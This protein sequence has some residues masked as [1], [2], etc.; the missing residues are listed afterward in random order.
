M[1]DLTVNPGSDVQLEFCDLFDLG[2][3]GGDV[4]LTT[5]AEQADGSLALGPRILCSLDQIHAID[6]DTNNL[7]KDYTLYKDIDLEN[8]EYSQS[9]INGDYA[10]TFDGNYKTIR[11]LNINSSS[12]SVGFFKKIKNGGGVKN[13]R[14][15]NVSVK[16][17]N[18]QGRSNSPPFEPS[19][20]GAL[21][22]EVKEGSVINCSVTDSDS[23]SDVLYESSS[24]GVAAGGLVGYG[25][26]L[27]IE[28]SFS[29][30]LRIEIETSTNSATSRLSVGGLVGHQIACKGSCST[31][32]DSIVVGHIERSY[33]A[34]Q[35]IRLEATVPFSSMGG[36]VGSV[37]AG[38]EVLGL[39]GQP[40]IIKD[41]YAWE[42]SMTEVSV[43]GQTVYLG[44][45]VGQLKGLYDGSQQRYAGDLKI[46]NSYTVGGDA[47][48]QNTGVG[49]LLGLQS[50]PGA[51]ASLV[52]FENSFSNMPFVNFVSASSLSV[53]SYIGGLYGRHFH[54]QSNTKD[55]SE[56]YYTGQISCSPGSRQDPCGGIGGDMF[57]TY[58][59]GVEEEFTVEN[60]Y[61]T[62]EIYQDARAY[63]RSDYVGLLF[64]ANL[65]FVQ[66]DP[67]VYEQLL[68][69]LGPATNAADNPSLYFRRNGI[70]TVVGITPGTSRSGNQDAALKSDD[71]PCFVFTETTDD[72]CLGLA[73]DSE[74]NITAG[75]RSLTPTQFQSVPSSPTV[76]TGTSPALGSEFL[77]T[78]GWCPRVCR[79]GSSSCTETSNTLVGFDENGDPLQGPG[80]GLKAQARNEGRNCFEPCFEFE[81]NNLGD[82]V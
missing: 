41:S 24:Y 1:S 20:V 58:G 75:N 6:G 21:A 7:S 27:I 63:N 2:A 78:A 57:G 73:V 4:G 45:L 59:E 81:G 77:Y 47:S 68:N 12:I 19:R 40:F 42:T 35:D 9:I 80:G 53:H 72:A 74:D 70:V 38:Q 8:V 61:S 5:A 3:S 67:S 14:L 43:S 44:G 34:Y 60:L 62:A 71:Q 54:G 49:G 25:L 31:G 69:I 79:D 33:V 82:C 64:S 30:G 52:T 50:A 32:S 10:G 17:T 29:E 39:Q 26:G 15:E 55:F 22:G 16:S 23:N 37:A 51:R 28:D 56:S 66:T 13:L 76:A 18:N 46:V 65:P 36:L 11:N 48:G